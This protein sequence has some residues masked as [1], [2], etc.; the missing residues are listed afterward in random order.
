VRLGVD[1]RAF[2]ST[3]AGTLLAAPLAAEGQPAAKVWRIGLF[4]VGLDHVPPSLDGLRDGL[5]ALGYEEG[6]NLQLDFRNVADEVAARVTAADQA[7]ARPDL[8]VAFETTR[9]P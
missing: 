6:K 4:H 5:K 7:R 3:L 2:I 1:R 9:T 8:L